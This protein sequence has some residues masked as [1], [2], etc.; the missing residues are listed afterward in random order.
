MIPKKGDHVVFIRPDGAVCDD[1]VRFVATT[2]RLL[3]PYAPN[4]TIV[5]V[6]LTNHSWCEPKDIVKI[7][8]RPHVHTV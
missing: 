2:Y 5:C 6:G 4:Q 1:V 7:I 8:R 3:M